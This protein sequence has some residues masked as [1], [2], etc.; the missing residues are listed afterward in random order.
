[1]V[2]QIIGT[3]ASQEQFIPQ[4]TATASHLGPEERKISR[5]KFWLNGL[6]GGMPKPFQHIVEF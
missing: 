6:F 3:F 2:T 5:Y 1:M 4:K